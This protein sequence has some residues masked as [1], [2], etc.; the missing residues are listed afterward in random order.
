MVLLLLVAGCPWIEVRERVQKC[1]FKIQSL[2]PTKYSLANP[3][4]CTLKI[5]ISINNPNEGEALLEPFEWR[6]F[7]EGSEIVKGQYDKQVELPPQ[8]TKN[9]SM[10]LQLDFWSLSKSIVNAILRGRATYR[11]EATVYL[12]T[13]FGTLEYEVVLQKGKWSTGTD[14]L[15][16]H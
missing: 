13:P 15:L 8:K 1:K 4:F 2:Y 9:L 3:R 14:L 10:E 5:N 16:P 7:V 11:M 12:S 6:L